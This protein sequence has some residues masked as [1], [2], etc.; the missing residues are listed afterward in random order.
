M[1]RKIK[2][3][4]WFVYKW[5]KPPRQKPHKVILRSSLS[6]IHY[7][8][9]KWLQVKE[10][11]YLIS[12]YSWTLTSIPNWTCSV[13]TISP[14]QCT[15]PSTWLTDWCMKPSTWLTTNLRRMLAAKFFSSST[16]W[17][18]RSSLV[19]KS[20]NVQ[21]QRLLEKKDE[22]RQIV[23]GQ[24]MLVKNLCI[25]LHSLALAVTALKIILI[26]V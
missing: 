12:T 14:F 18:S 8:H 5:G 3:T 16:R 23:F 9:N 2:L 1:H 25:K 26:Y 6:R 7:Y 13:V 21:T 20:Y 19:T 24:N 17:R 10:S 22:L 15:A 11:Q 4:R